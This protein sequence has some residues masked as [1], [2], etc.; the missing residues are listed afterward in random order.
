MDWIIA[1]YDV[2]MDVVSKVIAAAAAVAAILPQGGEAG[3]LIVNIRKLV[4]ILALNVGNA[5]NAQ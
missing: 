2:V 5:K 3:K 1:N 4:D